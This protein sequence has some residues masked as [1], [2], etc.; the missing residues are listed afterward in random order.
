MS[1]Y[2]RS[3][4]LEVFCKKGVLKNFADLRP[5]TLLKKRLWHRCFPVSFGKFLRTPFLQNTPRGL[6]L[7]GVN[8]PNYT[9]KSA[10]SFGFTCS[11]FYSVDG[12]F[13][14]RHFFDVVWKDVLWTILQFDFRQ[15]FFA[16]YLINI[17]HGYYIDYSFF[18]N[19]RSM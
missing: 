7:V 2:Y 15:T 9:T 8:F 13:T 17:Q 16:K 1:R 14:L 12:I 11:L 10:F 19:G 4:R 18:L 6:L 3:S 5:A